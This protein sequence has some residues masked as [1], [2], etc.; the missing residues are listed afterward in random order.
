MIYVPDWGYHYK[1]PLTNDAIKS[2]MLL[3]S[4]WRMGLLWIVSGVALAYMCGSYTM[5]KLVIKRTNQILLPLLIGVLFIVPLQLF[6]QMKQANDMPLSFIGFV[7]AFFIQPQ[8]YFVNYS[9]GIWPRFDVNHLWFLRSLWRFSI[10]LILVSPILNSKVAQ[11]IAHWLA[12]R[13]SCVLLLFFVPI[14]L[15]E[16]LMEGELVR[17]VY[18]FTLLFLG[19]FLGLHTAFW[20]TLTKHAWLL[21]MLCLMAMT[22]LQ[23]GFIEIWKP[24]LNQTNEIL[25]LLIKCIYVSNKILPLFAILALSYRYLNRP[26]KI[27]TLLNPFVF[28]LYILHQSVIIIVAYMASNSS[29]IFLKAPEYQLWFSLVVS[30]L[31][32]GLLVMVIANFNAL[33]MCFGMR[34][35]NNIDPYK[36]CQ[37]SLLVWVI[38]TP[39]IFRLI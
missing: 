4:P 26:N 21:S 14:S 31:I 18:G 33:R 13:L 34:F 11:K 20:R 27:V 38:C 25:N 36:S 30:P 37:V 28:P 2:F 17:E 29:F 32:C 15:I 16:W 24:G 39:M 35:K 10:I 3:T 12:S 23:I 5:I 6:A 9:S 8:Q 22:A 7:Q 19:F 1:N